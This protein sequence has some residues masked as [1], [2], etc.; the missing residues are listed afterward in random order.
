MFPCR[1]MTS[2]CFKD[3]TKKILNLWLDTLPAL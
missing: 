3:W 2:D 1:K